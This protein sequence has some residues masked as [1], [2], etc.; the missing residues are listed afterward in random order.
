MNFF[1]KGGSEVQLASPKLVFVFG[2]WLPQFPSFARYR[3]VFTCESSIIACSR[4][5]WKDY[6][7]WVHFTINQEEEIR[8]INWQ[9]PNIRDY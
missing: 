4:E 2:F 6:T 5:I 9:Q 3:S 8:V 7:L 1:S